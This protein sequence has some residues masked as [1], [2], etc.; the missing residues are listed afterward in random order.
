MAYKQFIKDNVDTIF[1]V[2][3]AEN[4]QSNPNIVELVKDGAV[5]LWHFCDEDLLVLD[6]SDGVFKEMWLVEEK[7]GG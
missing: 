1:T 2:S 4:Y 7:A 5:S 6:K 3:Y